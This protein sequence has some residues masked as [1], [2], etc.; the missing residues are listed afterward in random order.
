[1][2]KQGTGLRKYKLKYHCSECD[3]I[4]YLKSRWFRCPLCGLSTSLTK[5]E[6]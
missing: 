1:M 4:V 6:D 5:I 3:K 2:G